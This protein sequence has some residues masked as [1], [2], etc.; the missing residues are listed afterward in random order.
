MLTAHDKTAEDGIF[1]YWP[2]VPWFVTLLVK[3]IFLP[4]RQ[5]FWRFAPCDRH[6]KPQELP[7][8]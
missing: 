8:A 6:S 7:F 4:K 2:P 5:S 1:S 3:W